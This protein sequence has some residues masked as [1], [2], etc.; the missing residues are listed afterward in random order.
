MTEAERGQFIEATPPTGFKQ[1]INAFAEMPEAQRKGFIDEALKD[2]RNHPSHARRGPADY[3]TNGP[4][5]ISPE[6]EQKVRVMGLKSFYSDSSA[7]TKAELA[8]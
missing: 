5:P 2:L 4:P 8:R 1:M 6:L 3:G 7:Q